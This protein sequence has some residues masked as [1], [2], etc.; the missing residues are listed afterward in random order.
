M[1][2]SSLQI[3]NN[4]GHAELARENQPVNIPQA[5]QVNLED[6]AWKYAT[7][8]EVRWDQ[9]FPYQLVF[10]QQQAGGYK[11]M[12]GAVF[13]LPIPPED[14]SRSMPFAIDVTVTAGGIV[15]QHNGAP[16]RPIQF[17]GTTGLLP[18][19]GGGQPLPAR[20][21]GQS[22]FAGT[23]RGVNGLVQNV[24]TAVQGNQA[25]FKT[26]LV[27]DEEVQGSAMLRSTGYYQFQ[28]LQRFLEQYITLKKSKA[29]HNVVLG[30]AIHKEQAMYLVAPQDFTLRRNKAEPLL[31]NYT[32]SFKAWGRTIPDQTLGLEVHT[33]PFRDQD[34]LTKILT[35][36]SAARRALASAK[37]TIDGFGQDVDHTV[38]EPLRQTALFIKDIL[39]V[40]V[41]CA[42]LP[43]NI[44]RDMKTA[45][46]EAAGIP[47][48]ASGVR[49]A[50]GNLGNSISAELS[51]AR[52]AIT[53]FSVT[54]NKA[55]TQA[56]V[57]P[58][59]Q[60]VIDTSA[61]P[62]NT[63][64]DNPQDNF[65]LFE[66]LIPGQLNLTPAVQ[67]SIQAE[68][69]RLKTLTRTDF[70]TFRDN[71]EQ[72]SADY[73][74]SVGA[75]SRSYNRTYGRDADRVTTRV[76]TADE[77][78][79]L[80][81]LN[82][83][84]L[85][86]N[87]LAATTENATPTPNVMQYVAALAGPQDIPFQIPTSKFAVPFPY[88]STLEMVAARYLGSPDRWVEIATLNNLS[89][90][91][92]DEVGFERLL[93]TA[94]NGNQVE[95][96]DVSSLYVGQTIYIESNVSAR[97]TR[98]IQSIVAV[99][100][101]Y[102]LTVDGAADL[103]RFEPAAAAMLTAFLPNTV[104]SQKLLY[105]PSDKPEP[106]T[107]FQGPPNEVFAGLERQLAQGGADLLLTANGDLAITDDGDC[108][109]AIG[110]ANLVQRV[111]LAIDTPRGSLIHH[112]GYGFPT[113]V[114]QSTADLSAQQI[115]SN[116][117]TLF[118]GDSAFTG[119]QSVSVTKNGPAVFMNMTV[120]VA[121]TS[122]LLPITVAIPVS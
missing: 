87:R 45:I 111:R 72:F 70:A 17:Q 93:V 109:L 112:P 42:D 110:M 8:E 21:L 68:K 40:A 105:I 99:G 66:T 28:M 35:R 90:P 11:V 84:I 77:Y 61:D 119:V 47:R 6:A 37:S 18:L 69:N 63:I 96:S 94:G 65:E 88:G 27:T 100:N 108:R 51:A 33:S 46:L 91:Y 79:V 31:W 44:V 76:T 97:T 67:A 20:N 43:V 4:F 60:S 36:L 16:I 117:K 98:T 113:I 121:G 34:L 120:G 2:Y 39:G 75:G 7:V 41:T 55:A 106:Q 116:A 64:L 58:G 38:F 56:A 12:D 73:A 50:F 89:A 54:T 22:V 25:L 62:A 5:A 102:V 103:A 13:T 92:V 85:E 10:L 81:S 52:D 48:S 83:A 107:D 80:S 3:T 53:S 57:L 9:Q 19:R 49:G 114:G 24:R 78:G 122:E 118:S 32:L 82:D 104:N 1:A 30:L 29:G 101:N 86:L 26:N 59:S 115:L 15:E 23:L 71:L 95:V 74:D 14:L